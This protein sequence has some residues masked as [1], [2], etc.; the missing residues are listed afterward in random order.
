MSN[1]AF[2]R[3]GQVASVLKDPE[4]LFSPL[5]RK[6]ALLVENFGSAIARRTRGAQLALMRLVCEDQVQVF[7]NLP[8]SG[9]ELE[10]FV[11][12]NALTTP[13]CFV[14]VRRTKKVTYERAGDRS[15]AGL[16]L[17]VDAE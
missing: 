8:G 15:S 14:S 5:N 13:K 3:D 12:Q 9:L 11:R 6:Q 1:R 16:I 2:G 17:I 4:S 7:L 10:L